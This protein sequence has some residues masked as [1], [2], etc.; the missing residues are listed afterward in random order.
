[1]KLVIKNISSI[2]NTNDPTI[3][4]RNVVVDPEIYKVVFYNEDYWGN[5][6]IVIDR[7]KENVGDSYDVDFKNIDWTSDWERYTLNINQ[8]KNI[9][10][11]FKRLSEMCHDYDIINNK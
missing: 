11:F 6:E 2:K 4:I 1:M 8:M 5:W 9:Q 10:S 7:I 3:K